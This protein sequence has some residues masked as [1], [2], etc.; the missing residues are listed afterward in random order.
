MN[1]EKS[2][3]QLRIPR[4]GESI[5][6][7][8]LTTR[9][10]FWL[11]F[12]AH[13]TP[14][15]TALDPDFLDSLKGL[16]VGA[17]VLDVGCGW[18]RN[19]IPLLTAGG[20]AYLDYDKTGEYLGYGP[21]KNR[22]YYGIDINNNEIENNHKIFKDTRMKFYWAD[23]TKLPQKWHNKFDVVVMA[24]ALGVVETEVR[25][26][27]LKEAYRVAKPGK[28]VMAVEFML[29]DDDPEQAKRYREDY[30]KTKESG[31]E[32]G[33]RIILD[34]DG[35]TFFIATHF[36]E[37]KFKRLFLEAGFEKIE[38]RKRLIVSE[39]VGKNSITKARW[40]MTAWGTKPLADNQS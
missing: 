39:G 28:K 5:I 35:G 8:T 30:E 13:E 9:E 38:I 10:K 4:K 33:D 12:K 15:T 24:A 18:A 1:H 21:K 2:E 11:K 6:S 22:R 26:K 37:E 32:Y 25:K 20:R 14:A 29:N 34:K 7:D 36:T 3:R 40:Q 16:R 27:L 31:G 17:K 19:A 23:G